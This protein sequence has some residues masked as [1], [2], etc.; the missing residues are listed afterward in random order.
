M[1][2]HFLYVATGSGIGIISRGVEGGRGRGEVLR[3][4][5]IEQTE[6]LPRDEASDRSF[7]SFTLPRQPM[8]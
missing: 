6:L 3:R 1:D 5:M 7:S 8:A 2:S 4:G